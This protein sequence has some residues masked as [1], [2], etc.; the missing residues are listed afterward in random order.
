MNKIQQK[1]AFSENFFSN[2]YFTSEKSFLFKLKFLQ[3]FAV[4]MNQ[5]DDRNADG[6]Q[7]KNMHE[8]AFAEQN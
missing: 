2:F 7:K 5:F 4:E 1:A 3:I 8:T 6:G